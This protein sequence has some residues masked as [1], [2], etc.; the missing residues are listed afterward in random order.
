M[1][2]L[3]LPTLPE[4]AGDSRN[5]SQSPARGWP[6]DANLP[7]FRCP[8][9]P[10]MCFILILTLLLAV[11]WLDLPIGNV[12]CSLELPESQ[13]INKNLPEFHLEELATLLSAHDRQLL[14]RDATA[15]HGS[16]AVKPLTGRFTNMRVGE[17]G[18]GR[19]SGGLQRPYLRVAD[20]GPNRAVEWICLLRFSAQ[21]GIALPFKSEDR[22][23]QRGN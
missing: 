22:G 21:C 5:S 6:G 10:K 17:G 12:I 18:G 14:A 4:W 9:C 3:G 1:A 8:E 20:P 7:E 16:A 23:R 13:Y 2:L 11:Q 15:L 19:G